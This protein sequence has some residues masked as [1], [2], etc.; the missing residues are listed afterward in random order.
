M[1]A[2]GWPGMGHPKND[3]RP[4]RRREL[5]ISAAAQFFAKKWLPKNH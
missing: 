4:G 2:A 1:F 5:I 3:R